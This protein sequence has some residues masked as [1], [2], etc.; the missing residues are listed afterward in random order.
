MY[1]L[2]TKDALFVKITNALHM[3]APHKKRVVLRLQIDTTEKS[4]TTYYP[5]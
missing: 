2:S 5:G 3:M 4:L 1:V